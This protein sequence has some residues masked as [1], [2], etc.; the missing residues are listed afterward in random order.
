MTDHHQ[1]SKWQT[2]KQ[3]CLIRYYV[4]NPPIARA[5]LKKMDSQIKRDSK[6]KVSKKDY[7]KAEGLRIFRKQLNNERKE[8]GG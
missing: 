4:N 5:K 3:A 1:E 8:R 6:G 2:E 7:E